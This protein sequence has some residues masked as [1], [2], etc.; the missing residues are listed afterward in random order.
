MPGPAVALAPLILGA[1][2]RVAVSAAGKQALKMG[3][4]AIANKVLSGG[5]DPQSA[6][7]DVGR[8]SSFQTGYQQQNTYSTY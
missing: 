4:S 5:E 3:A 8:A 7:Q 2:G 1:V 6:Q